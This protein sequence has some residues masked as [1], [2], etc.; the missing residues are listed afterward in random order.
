MLDVFSYPVSALMKTL[1][2][3]LGL[4]TDPTSGLAWAGS[5]VLLVATVRLLLLV[6]TWRQLQASHRMAALRPRL[7]ALR[8]QHGDD[9]AG[10]LAA[11]RQ[12]QSEEG[13]GLAG[14]LPVLLQLPVFLGL[15]HLLA[16]FTVGGAGG[17]GVF[18]A[19]EV[20]SFAHATV[21]GVPL[22]AAVRTPAVVLGQLA[23]GLDLAA[24]LAV[25]GPLLLVAA[26]AAFLGA[27]H[28]RARQ[29]LTAPA[30]DD[31]VG[32]ALRSVGGTMVWMA[33][34]GVLVSGLVLPVPL[35][36]VLYWAVNGTWT[37][38]QTWL[39]TRRLDGRAV[40]VGRDVGPGR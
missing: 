34:A 37:T 9:R 31:A 38:V 8:E 23:P 36:L 15:Y 28:A 32:A 10:Y 26:A 5:V 7:T 13:V 14:C 25:A 39:L 27:R 12:L 33:P 35:A 18:G 19:D 21:A 24:V 16:G 40:G 3:L 17:N 29:A 4:V 11:A 6:P 30:A 22:S 2:D 20:D 1:H